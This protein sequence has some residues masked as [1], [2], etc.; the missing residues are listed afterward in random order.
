MQRNDNLFEELPVLVL[1]GHV[2][3]GNDRAEDFEHLCKPVVA[4]TLV[5]HPQQQIHYLLFDLVPQGHELSVDSVHQCFQVVPLSRILTVKEIDHLFREGLRNA[6]AEG[7]AGQVWRH[8]EFQQQFVHQLQVRPLFFEVRLVFIR[9]HGGGL[10]GNFVGEGPENVRLDELQRVSED[11]VV[12]QLDCLRVIQNVNQLDQR[13][14]LLIL[15]FKILF[16]I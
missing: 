5:R 9:V 16:G 3:A 6:V 11:G 8:D 2:V 12:E 4:V 15:K 7:L 14:F 1:E 13:V 10:F